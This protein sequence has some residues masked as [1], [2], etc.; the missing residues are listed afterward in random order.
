MR[1]L[2]LGSQMTSGAAR[3]AQCPHAWAGQAG[4]GELQENL[5]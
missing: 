1:A 3:E 2:A 4:T 5:C